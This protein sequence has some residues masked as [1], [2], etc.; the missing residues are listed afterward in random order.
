MRYRYGLMFMVLLLLAAPAF[1]QVVTVIHLNDIPDVACGEAWVQDGVDMHFATTTKEDCDG[2][3]SCN[4][5]HDSSG[6]WL[7]PAR[8]VAD[9]GQSYEVTRVEI[10]IEDGCGVGCTKAFLY[11]AGSLVAYAENSDTG[12]QTLILQPPSK[13]P[14]DAL[15]V[16]SCEGLVLGST[17]RIYA[18]AL[19]TDDAGWGQ[20]K[21][22]YR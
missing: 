6:A 3:G 22:A 11:H 1:A 20:I 7:F 9:F 13:V 16:S 12:T 21:R 2:G 5:G 18:D 19:P 14:A 8:L 15:A 10:D 17:I 4:F